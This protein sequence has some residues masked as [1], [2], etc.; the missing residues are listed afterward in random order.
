MRKWEVKGKHTFEYLK[1]NSFVGSIGIGY[2]LGSFFVSLQVKHKCCWEGA[3][4]EMFLDRTRLITKWKM[5]G[6]GKVP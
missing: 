4:I 5:Q 2:T 1:C 6:L 3:V